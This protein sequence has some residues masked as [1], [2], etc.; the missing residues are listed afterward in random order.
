MVSSVVLGTSLAFE[1]PEPDVMRRS[2]RDPARRILDAFLVWRVVFVSALFTAGIFGAYRWGLAQGHDEA[3]A[4]TI[5]VNALVAMEIFY[6][7]A[8]RYL[9]SPSMTLAGA[10]GTPAVLIVVTTVTALQAVFT[11]VPFM[12][13]VFGSRPLGWPEL[14]AVLAAGVAVLVLLEAEKLARRALGR[15]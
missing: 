1:P 13:D 12:N 7:F 8:V 6:L 4:R 3:T 9:D 14:G 15:A 11:Y 5:A 2:P 10:L